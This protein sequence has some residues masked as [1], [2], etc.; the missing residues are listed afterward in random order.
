MR[1]WMWVLAIFS[2]FQYPLPLFAQDADVAAQLSRQLEQLYVAQRYE[3]AIPIA[4]QALASLKAQ[5]P[6]EDYH[7]AIVLK[8]LADM[9]AALGKYSEAEPYYRRALAVD[10]RTLGPESFLISSTL[11]KLA[12]THR[13]LN[14]PDA[15]SLYKRALA[16]HE[17][18]LGS[19]HERVAGVL[20]SLAVLYIQQD[21]AVEAEAL[22]KRALSIEET[23][24]GLVNLES[25]T[26]L[27]NLGELYRSQGRLKEAEGFFARALDA[28]ERLWGKDDL[29]VATPLNNLAALYADQGRLGDATDATARVARILESK[30][31]PRHPDLANSLN[32]LGE[33]Y[34]RQRMFGDSERVLRKA[35]SILEET[36]GPHHPGVATILNNIAALDQDLGRFAE[37]EA[38]L[39]RVVQIY[40]SEYGVESEKLGQTYNNLASLQF[41]QG[42]W[43]TAEQY[44]KQ[45]TAIII[46]RARLRNGG[47]SSSATL[48]GSDETRRLAFEFRD[49]VKAAYRAAGT[50]E[51]EQQRL[52]PPLFE[53]AQ[54]ALRSEAAD[55]LAQMAARGATATAGLARIVRER[56]D[57]LAEWNR[58]DR[59]QTAAISRA[60]GMRDKAAEAANSNRLAE[61]GKRTAAIDA[62]MKTEFPD[63]AALASPEPLPVAQV[64]A[65]LHPD[66]VLILF[67]DTPP[68][69]QSRGETFIWV[70]TKTGMRWVRSD[71]GTPSLQREVA[72]LRC[73]L[74]YD[75][76]W[77]AEE[78]PCAALTKTSYTSDDRGRGRPLPFDLARAHALYAALFGQVEDLIEGK[79]L[80]IIPSGALTQ[81]PFQVLV[82]KAPDPTAN[83][84]GAVRR[85]QWLIRSHAIT[86]LPAV[87]S[88]KALRRDAKPSRASRPMIGFGNP[89]LDGAG[90][91]DLES[92]RV[93]RTNTACPVKVASISTADRG[94]TQLALRRGI[95]D[96]AQIRSAPP[97]PETADELCAVAK[98]LHVDSRDIYLGARATVPQVMRLSDSGELAEYRLIHFATHGALSGEITGSSEPGLILTPPATASGADDGYLSASKIAALK[99]DADWVILSACNTAAGDATNADALSGLARAFFYAG[100]RALLVSHWSVDSQATVKLITGALGRMTIDKTAGRAEALQQSML[101]LIDSGGAYEA[102]PEIWA[103][104][105]VVGEGSAA[106]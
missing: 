94:V 66:E 53:T 35:Q 49:L 72:A 1:G 101:A 103:P 82:A 42:H 104:F 74:D 11:L 65:N 70:V 97:L 19:Q 28:T 31:G 13:L 34:R 76:S 87:S 71:L 51:A 47:Q 95:A 98:D 22:L 58:R 43:K 2:M 39:A 18:T 16:I 29:K 57:L 36:Y 14:I 78:S 25:G 55:S 3:E 100:A 27:G 54:W 99:L 89:L 30:L 63:Y 7:H 64:Q 48:A 83:G 37:A 12:D 59:A 21:R 23:A 88:L 33:L 8:R 73:G 32:N 84:A 79:Q 17:K 62:L 93:A 41:N 60:P 86:V 52:G 61:I 56:Q 15:E 85:A 75:G 10:E 45:S 68:L 67:L 26:I 69:E 81:L 46:H 102:Y 9:Y 40:S 80:L 38:L 91:I 92:A 44:W 105:V 77:A 90:A 96:V 4:I 6:H 106:Q 50:S 20:N 5:Y 24:K